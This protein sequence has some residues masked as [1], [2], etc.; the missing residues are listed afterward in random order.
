MVLS[1]PNTRLE[2]NL[3][4]NK[5]HENDPFLFF[6][7]CYKLDDRLAKRIS[8]NTLHRTEGT[9][10]FAAKLMHV[11]D[12][13]SDR[14]Q[15]LDLGIHDEDCL[16]SI[17]QVL[18]NSCPN[19][20]QLL[21]TCVFNEEEYVPSEEIQELPQKPNLTVFELN[22]EVVA[23]SPTLTRFAQL[24]VNASPNLRKLEISWG[25]YPDLE[26]SK[27]LDSLT[28][29]LDDVRPLDVALRDLKPSE[30][31]RM[32]GQVGD[33]LVH[34]AFAYC[35]FH[36][37]DSMKE[38]YN[39]DNSTQRGIRLPGKMS[40]L[41]T[42]QNVIIDFIQHADFW[43]DIERMPVLESL[44]I[45]KVSKTKTSVDTI[46]KNLPE[47]DFRKSYEFVD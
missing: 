28:L 14:V 44:T 2:L 19:L 8:A 25:V 31:T 27:S 10:S 5:D 3:D 17:F 7:L 38:K 40:K 30:V 34:L 16:P 32:L 24:V 39:L 35:R 15:L 1:L 4:S 47:T 6:E 36:Q 23:A 22:S 11:C 18:K 20:K 12:K 21:I 37:M 42:F 46:L 29:H 9:Y 33:Q 26:T 13:F 45:G 43:E 41:R